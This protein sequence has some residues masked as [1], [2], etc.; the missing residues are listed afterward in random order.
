M[1]YLFQKY[2]HMLEQAEKPHRGV[3]VFKDADGVVFPGPSKSDSSETV[4]IAVMERCLRE[5]ILRERY[6]IYME[7]HVADLWEIGATD[8]ALKQ[9]QSGDNADGESSESTTD[10]VTAF[11]YRLVALFLLNP[12]QSN[13][14]LSHQFKEFGRNIAHKRIPELVKHFQFAWTDQSLDILSNLA[15]VSLVAPSLI[16][17]DPVTRVIYLNP[18]QTTVNGLFSLESKVVFSYLLAVVDGRV[19]EFV[20][21]SPIVALLVFGIPTMFLGCVGYLC[22]CLDERYDDTDLHTRDLPTMDEAHAIAEESNVPNESDEPEDDESAR[23]RI[24]LRHA[25]RSPKR[26]AREV[27][28]LGPVISKEE[29]EAR[30]AA[31]QE[32]K[33]SK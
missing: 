9:S 2:A 19:P 15:M 1:D 3:I 24:R 18:N 17:V 4:T 25:T 6:P 11:P 8:M 13:D 14:D 30:R 5:W 26:A 27:T 33:K 22:C 28:E 21:T 12:P 7:A 29:V 20:R 31:Y 10:E 23:D 32:W 16:V